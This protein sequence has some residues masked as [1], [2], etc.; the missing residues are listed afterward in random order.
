M[1]KLVGVIR[2]FV[3]I[4]FIISGFIKLN[5]PVGFS[6]KLQEYFSP[7]VLNMEFLS[8]FALGLAILLVI[9]ELVLG[10]ALIIGYY[11]K[12]TMWLL[13]LMILFFTFLTF[14][15]AYFNKVT[16]CGCFGDALP[17]TP[18]QSFSKDVVL[19]ILILFLFF[20][21]KHI[22]PFF[23]NF[24]R[25]IVIF[26]TFI[27]CLS[28]GYYVLMHLPV[29]DFRAYKVGVN[30]QEG[31]EI[32]EGAEKAVFDYHWKFDVNGSQKI[33]TT[34]GEYPSSE[35]TFLGVE[36]EVVTQ[37]YV[38]P[39]HDFTIEKEGENY[40][41][42]FLNTPNL[43]VIIAY[44]INKTEWNGW[45][46]IKE[47][48][49]DA[50]KK[51]Y[52][53][54]GLTSSGENEVNDLKEK[55]NINFDFYF[56]DATVLKTIV[57][58]N[59][60]ILKLHNGTILQKKHWNDAK[61]IDLEVLPTAKSAL[62]LVLKNKLDS[63]SRYDQLY[64]PL[65]QESDP[66]KREKLAQDL[67]IAKEDYTG[68]LWKKQ[69]MIDT[70][71]LKIIKT[72]LDNYGYP[73]K[74]LVGEPTNL[75]ALEV[76]RHNPIQIEEYLD[77]FKK[78][79]A[80]GEIPMTQVAALEDKYLMQ[81]RKEQLYG[82]QAQITAANGFFIW[83]IKDPESVNERRAAAGFTSTIEEYATDLMGKNASY[84]TLKLSDIKTL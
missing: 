21:L 84:K 11:K 45:P 64:R 42:D 68:D 25:S 53:V 33:I 9:V 82:T 38:P 30:I 74:S 62:N 16:D 8:P 48:T 22:Q 10:V 66:D 6:F 75:I 69:R 31:M 73:G 49:N 58:S 32:P 40:T 19:L 81:Q 5:D 51:G 44:D 2:I 12:P 55:Q 50:L 60:G 13:L 4:L 28:F 18:W 61:E 83:P 35:G 37:G 56:T 3:G 76:I 34:Q 59:P 79:A 7:D 63:I 1:K 41:E 43:I 27:G 24:G 14:Y 23:S 71:N 17:L 72:I 80:Q 47:L 20:N 39:I 15:S 52:T 29:F 70:S 46:V 65:L 26:A 57:R 67:G 54:I 78:A 36:T 77:L